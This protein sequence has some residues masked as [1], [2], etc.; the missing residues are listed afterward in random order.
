VVAGLLN[1]GLARGATPEIGRYLGNLLIGGGGPDRGCALRVGPASGPPTGRPC[2][3]GGRDRMTARL[4]LP[5]ALVV[6]GCLVASTGF[7]PP[8]HSYFAH[9]STHHIAPP[10]HPIAP[11]THRRHST[12]RSTR[13]TAL[14]S[15]HHVARHS[16]L[17][18]A[19]RIKRMRALSITATDMPQAG[20]LP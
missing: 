9:R 15:T 5:A 1:V 16:T 18:S 19:R 12:H 13:H 4:H 20:I 10:L 6:F 2:R 17:R 7:R 14:R 3:T 11:P 8:L